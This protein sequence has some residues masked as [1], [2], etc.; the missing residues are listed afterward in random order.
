M[1]DQ[2]RQRNDKARSRNH[3]QNAL[4]KFSV[5]LTS[6]VLNQPLNVIVVATFKLRPPLSALNSIA[7]EAW[8]DVAHTS[9]R[10]RTDSSLVF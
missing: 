5:F 8:N 4:R 7:L 2:H 6:Q 10:R 1:D 9:E 3:D